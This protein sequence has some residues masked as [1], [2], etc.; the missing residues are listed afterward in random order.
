MH[1]YINSPIHPL[2]R[3]IPRKRKVQKEGEVQT[4]A[5]SITAFY[6]LLCKSLLYLPFIPYPWRVGMKKLW[7]S[8]ESKPVEKPKLQVGH[9]SEAMKQCLR[10]YKNLPNQARQEQGP[11]AMNLAKYILWLLSPCV[12]HCSS[13]PHYDILSA[14]RILN[15]E[16]FEGTLMR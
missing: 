9:L 2:H 16:H 14:V 5:S 4:P 8:E 13:E 1:T 12:I 6:K 10:A 11:A 3:T 15:F 7:W